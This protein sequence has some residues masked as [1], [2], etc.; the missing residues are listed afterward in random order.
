MQ[1]V[2]VN[3]KQKTQ[4]KTVIQY[5]ADVGYSVNVLG[6]RGPLNIPPQIVNPAKFGCCTS[7][8]IECELIVHT[9][10]MDD[11]IQ[12]RQTGQ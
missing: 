2:T 6:P 3:D 10:C 7:K 5:S 4:L 11:M 12:D 1:L 9:G 8:G